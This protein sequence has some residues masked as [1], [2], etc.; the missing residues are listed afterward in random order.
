MIPIEYPKQSQAKEVVNPSVK[1]ETGNEK[2]ET[3][4]S[5][6]T[7]NFPS[8]N[9]TSSTKV[10]TEDDQLKKML[11]I[12]NLKEIKREPVDEEFGGS[13]QEKWDTYDDTT[14]QTRQTSS[15]VED[16]SFV[17]ENTIGMD[18]ETMSEKVTYFSN[19]F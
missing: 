9:D 13:D 1:V 7:D 17:P 5:K 3:L 4:A 8:S 18:N 6:K 16:D 15:E 2:N 19:N 14:T 11:S 12:H 10:P